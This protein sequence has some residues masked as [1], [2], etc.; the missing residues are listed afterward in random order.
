MQQM[1]MGLW[2]SFPLITRETELKWGTTYA[3]NKDVKW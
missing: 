1:V 3:K 2:D